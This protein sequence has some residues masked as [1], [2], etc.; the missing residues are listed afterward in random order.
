MEIKYFDLKD[1]G[2]AIRLSRKHAKISQGELARRTNLSRALISLLER[3]EGNP[4]V[5]TVLALCSALS[6]EIVVEVRTDR[7]YP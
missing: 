1:I 7:A 6:I 5:Q 4:S 2:D 3:G